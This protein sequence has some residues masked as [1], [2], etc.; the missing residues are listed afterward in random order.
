MGARSPSADANCHGRDVSFSDAHSASRR[1]FGVVQSVDLINRA[2]T[3][4][5]EAQAMRLD[6]PQTCKIL[7]HG[8]PV[9]LHLLQ[10]R[11]RVRATYR[12]ERGTLVAQS[13]EVGGC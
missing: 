12:C 3:V 4:V 11:D 9:K 10:P 7:L 1:A 5:R 2:M 8:E 6:V 13:I